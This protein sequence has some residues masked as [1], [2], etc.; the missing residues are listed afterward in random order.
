[1]AKYLDYNGLTTVVNNVK[2]LV[3]VLHITS[4]QDTWSTTY[5]RNSKASTYSALV[6]VKSLNTVVAKNGSYAYT[7]WNARGKFKSYE[8][9][10]TST[11]TGVTLR[12]STL[13]Y[14]TSEKSLYFYHGSLNTVG[15]SVEWT[16]IWKNTLSSGV[17]TVT[18]FIDD[19]GNITSV[20]RRLNENDNY[21][22]KITIHN[23]TGKNLEYRMGC[24]SNAVVKYLIYLK[25]GQRGTCTVEL[26]KNQPNWY[27][28][29]FAV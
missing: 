26:P 1:M 14:C 23:T 6:Y 8:E 3:D 21:V 18:P 20:D 27:F 2:S 12:N 10:G 15:S 5:I 28:V 4:V 22:F 17:H 7:Q 29:V 24:G 9:Y 19:T 11:G 16:N 25:N 13:I